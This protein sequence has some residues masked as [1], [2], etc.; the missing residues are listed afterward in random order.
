[1]KCGFVYIITNKRNT[2][3]YV[4]VTSQ[5][6]DRIFDHKRGRGCKF[7]AKYKIDKLVWFDEFPRMREALDREKQIKNWKREW[8]LNLIKELNPDLNDLYDDL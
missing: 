5:L 7:S 1:M 2:V 6:K 8:K 3:L 4:G